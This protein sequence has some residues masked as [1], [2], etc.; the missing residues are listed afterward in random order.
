MVIFKNR[1]YQETF[2]LLSPSDRTF[3]LYCK[4]LP[5]LMK[6]FLE[7]IN[8]QTE[9]QFFLALLPTGFPP[10]HLKFLCLIVAKVK[11]LYT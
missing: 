8:I 6:K 2:I 9:K 11:A 1:F 3:L 5:S 7:K 4:K 10:L